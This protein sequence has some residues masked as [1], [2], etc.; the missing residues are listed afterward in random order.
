MRRRLLAACI[1]LTVLAVT[2][3]AVPL[4]VVIGQRQGEQ[5]RSELSLVAVRAADRVPSDF[6]SGRSDEVELRR[7]EPDQRVAL[8]DVGGV[9]RAGR[10]PARLDPGGRAAL[11]DHVVSFDTPTELVVT[12][13]V[14]A[15]TRVVGA[16][17]AAE[18]LAVGRSS[19][20]SSRLVLLAVGLA[21]IA[22][23]GTIAVV[24]ARRLSRP[25]ETLGAEAR[26][27]GDGD[28]T[29]RPSASGIS[30]VDHV[31]ATL[32][33]SAQRVGDLLARE[34]AFSADASHQLRTP[35]TGLRLTLENEL[36]AP[37]HDPAVALEEALTDVDRLES[38]VDE[39]LALA[40]DTMGTRREVVDVG[41][42][43]EDRAA[44]W[45]RRLG[46]RALTVTTPD[47]AVRVRCAR[48]AV[49]HVLDVLVDN[50][51][52]HGTGEVRI[53]VDVRRDTAVLV[54]ADQGA[55]P[56]DAGLFTR[57]DPQA[58]G[59][60]IGLALARRLAEA[61]G[62]RLAL[63]GS[64]TTTFELLLPLDQA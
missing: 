9:R 40:R 18:P 55:R 10:G 6:T 39:L 50:A 54:V 23:A 30:E 63:T 44:E 5:N 53:G 32:A 12:V 33:A 51:G 47:A 59:T 1:G 19:V 34:Q 17:R 45:R 15:G 29:V 43:V 41:R 64:P 52:E 37:R 2:L 58:T 11:R 49:A 21:V 62:G 31:G 60:G 7:T 42:M 4:A 14:A 16:V 57:R 28:F 22:V 38:T 26:R 8:Y 20:R 48:T 13:P 27:I 35:L 56:S 61:E 3:F 46:A 24:V 25:L 36:A